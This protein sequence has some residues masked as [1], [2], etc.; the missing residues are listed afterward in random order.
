[1]ESLTDSKGNRPFTTSENG[2]SGIALVITTLLATWMVLC[3]F[4]RLYMRFTASIWQGRR[5]LRGRNGGRPDNAHTFFENT[6]TDQPIAGF[7]SCSNDRLS[8]SHISRLW[9]RS[10]PLVR[11]AGRPSGKSSIR[12]RS[13]LH[14][15]DCADEMLG[16]AA[17][18][19]ANVDSIAHTY[20]LRNTGSVLNVGF[21]CFPGSRD[22]VYVHRTLAA[23][24]SAMREY[25]T[26]DHTCIQVN[27]D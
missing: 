26:F 21:G 13:A 3:F 1:M 24:W 22:Q 18:R 12:C 25:C 20:L 5:F 4:V 23:G 19:A 16:F 7:R 8:H 14:C 2:H 10:D 9:E 11:V 6:Y 27:A 17:V 15:H